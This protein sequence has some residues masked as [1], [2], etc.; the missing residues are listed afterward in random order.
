MIFRRRS[1]TSPRDCT[2]G[3]FA[4]GQSYSF[5]H[6]SGPFLAR[7]FGFIKSGSAP[8]RTMQIL[9][10]TRTRNTHPYRGMIPMRHRRRNLPRL[11]H[12]P[13]PTQRAQKRACSNGHLVR[14]LTFCP[15][16][17]ENTQ[18]VGSVPGPVSFLSICVVY[19]AG[20]CCHRLHI[21]YFFNVVVVERQVGGVLV[22]KRENTRVPSFLFDLNMYKYDVHCL[23][24]PCC[25]RFVHSP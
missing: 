22:Q 25:A 4:L 20:H 6:L 8:R 7:C 12:P 16:L 15:L 1:F 3:P 10:R 13:T 21:L 18:M 24:L 17:H 14:H 19:T 23:P 11:L 9:K 2:G 5:S